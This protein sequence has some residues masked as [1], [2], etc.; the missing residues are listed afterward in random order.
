[1]KTSRKI[2]A[3]KLRG[4]F[5]GLN[6]FR[7]PQRRAAPELAVESLSAR[8]HGRLLTQYPVGPAEVFISHDGEVGYYEV[9]EP[10][11][12][13]WERR[14]YRDLFE[15]FVYAL[16]PEAVEAEDPAKFVE[17][18]IWKA[19]EDLGLLEE[20]RKNFAKYR[21]FVGRD[22]GYGKLHV[23]MLDPDV[24]E[25]TAVGYGKPVRVIH[26]K[27][28]GL[29]WLRTNIEFHSEGEIQNYNLRLAQRFGKSL[30]AAVPMADI[31]TPEGHRVSLTFGDEVTSP[32]STLSI[33]KFPIEPFSLAHLVADGMLSPLMAAYLWQV[34][35]HRGFVQVLGHVGSG[36][37]TLLNALLASIDPNAKV[38]TLEDVME[39]RL[40]H[41]NWQRFHTRP[42]HFATSERFE[43]DMF[44]LLTLV[45]RHRPDYVAVGEARGAEIRNLTHASALGHSCASTFHSDSPG[46]ALARMRADPMDLKDEDILRIWCFPVTAMIRRQS[47]EVVY[48]VTGIHEV[49][50]TEEGKPELSEIFEYDA[51][52]D[53]FSPDSP[54]EVVKRSKRLRESASA[55]GTDERELTEELRRK[56]GFLERLLKHRELGF[57]QYVRRVREFYATRGR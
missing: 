57:E 19:A 43:V 13:G 46:A 3:A 4:V 39:L 49:N 32:G 9:S 17:G 12:S 10:D 38:I 2:R 40:P 20:L 36:K 45:M 23:P 15:S 55:R 44:D 21:Y 54:R 22:L 34:L 25:I 50:P 6:P 11:L 18:A 1:M 56:A 52:T 28:A 37:T 47:G 29:G 51:R 26:R 30:T 33:R 53:S 48:R 14:V 41:E 24:A 31:V 7:S 16:E 8:V 27:L 42:V 5:A 35:E